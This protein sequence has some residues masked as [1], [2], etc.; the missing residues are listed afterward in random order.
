MLCPGEDSFGKSNLCCGCG[1]SGA[2]S[3]SKGLGAS[4]FGV[5]AFGCGSGKPALAFGTGALGNSF[6]GRSGCGADVGVGWMGGATSR[7]TRG[8]TRTLGDGGSGFV[9][10]FDG[11]NAPGGSNNF[12]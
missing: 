10:G 7:S 4:V 11:S 8:S 9:G 6:T 1:V 5:G 3:F 12:N 2:S